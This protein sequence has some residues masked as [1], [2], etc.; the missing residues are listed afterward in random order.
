MER[1]QEIYVSTDVETDGPIPGE[2]SLLSFGSAAFSLD[3][4]II[5]TFSVNLETLPGAKQD[6]ETMKWWATQPQ[7]WEECRKNLKSPQTAMREYLDW[8][9]ILPGR[10]V[11]VAYPVSFD[12]SFIYW[13]LIKFAGKSPFN[14]LGLDIKSY[15]MA[16]LKKPFY[17]VC[18]SNMP[19]VWF[20]SNK[21]SHVALEDAIEQAMLFCNIVQQNLR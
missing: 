14:Y 2:Y 18:K 11:F 15:A 8:F 6:P 13:Y 1:R 5:A 12:F 9:K 3:K 19:K 16:V 20:D 21:K 17:E 10:P 4:T 7:A